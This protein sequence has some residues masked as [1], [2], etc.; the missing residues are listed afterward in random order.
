MGQYSTCFSLTLNCFEFKENV[1]TLPFI[2]TPQNL[3]KTHTH[4]QRNCEV[5]VHASDWATKMVVP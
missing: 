3:R 2:Y 1:M 4:T 5:G